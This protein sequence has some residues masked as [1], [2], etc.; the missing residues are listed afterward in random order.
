M[1]DDLHTDLA[2][3]QDLASES[4]SVRYPVEFRGSAG[5]YF[6]IWIVNILLCI[7]TLYIYSPWAKVRTKRYFYGNTFI[8]N[9]SF[10]YLAT[11]MQIF[12][13]RLIAVVALLIATFAGALNPILG[14]V[15]FLLLAI[16]TPWVIWRSLRFNARMSSFRNLRFGFQRKL[17][18]LYG[19][20]IAA[21]AT[22]FL[23]VVAVGAA[24]ALGLISEEM[25]AALIGVGTLFFYLSWPWVKKMLMNYTVNGYRYG[26]SKFAAKYRT[27][28]TY[29]IYLLAVLVGILAFAVVILFFVVVLFLVI[30]LVTGNFGISFNDIK[31]YDQQLPAV[32]APLGSLIPFVVMFFVFLMGFAYFRATMRSYYYGSA[33]LTDKITFQSSAKTWSLFWVMLGNYVVLIVTLGLAYPWAS[34]RLAKYFASNTTVISQGS[35]DDFVAGE[36]EAMSALGEE[37]G[38][39]F[40]MD[41]DIAI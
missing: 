11:P 10:D 20:L 36:Q 15:I 40:D 16:A 26:A 37:L 5:E 39:A 41:M 3:H 34:V 17:L 35:L 1:S 23:I 12:K 32:L 27:G 2:V 8:D 31:N 28:R 33:K 14:I 6:P 29:W 38:E 19:I 13:G 30:Y 4:R 24:T 22:V 9:N 18:P 7:I 25:A 21:P